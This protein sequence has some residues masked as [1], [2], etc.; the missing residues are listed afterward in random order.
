ME[1]SALVLPSPELAFFNLLPVLLGNIVGESVL[2]SLV[3]QLVY[4]R[5][6]NMWYFCCSARNLY[7][8]GPGRVKTEG[9]E[10][11]GPAARVGRGSD[12]LCGN[13]RNV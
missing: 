3:Y 5:Q 9:T 11:D 2:V 4:H 12:W 1:T 8:M 7:L 13:G 10:I 6:A